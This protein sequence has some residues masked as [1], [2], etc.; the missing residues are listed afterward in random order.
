[1]N[2]I[3]AHHSRLPASPSTSGESSACF[4]LSLPHPP[5]ATF[6]S[7]DSVARGR[8]RAFGQNADLINS[9][10]SPSVIYQEPRARRQ[11]TNKSP[12][13]SLSLRASA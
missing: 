13:A 1:M 10:V 7:N 5:R 3:S 8:W 12:P 2:R 6:F 11:V 9:L 4:E